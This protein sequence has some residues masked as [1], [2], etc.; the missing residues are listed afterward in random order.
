MQRSGNNLYARQ[1]AGHH[2]EED[3]GRVYLNIELRVTYGGTTSDVTLQIPI[4]CR[5][6]GGDTTE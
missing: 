1:A 5:L 4:D 6:R 2:A 3:A